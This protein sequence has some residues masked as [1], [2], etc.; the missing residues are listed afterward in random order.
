[1]DLDLAR[2]FNLDRPIA[3]RVLEKRI[4]EDFVK[5]ASHSGLDLTELSADDVTGLYDQYRHLASIK[6]ANMAKIAEAIRAGRAL[7][8]GI[9]KAAQTAP[10]PEFLHKIQVLRDFLATPGA[11]AWRQRIVQEPELLKQLI[12]HGALGAKGSAQMLVQSGMGGGT[13]DAAEAAIKALMGDEGL[14]AGAAAHAPLRAHL[15]AFSPSATA[16][17]P[18]PADVLD[19][20][21]SGKLFTPGTAA[22]DALQMKSWSPAG[23]GKAMQAKN[24]GAVAR[25]GGPLVAGGA[26]LLYLLGKRRESQDLARSGMMGMSGQM[27]MQ[28]MNP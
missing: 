4:K 14:K 26:G 16:R 8:H 6:M 1:M 23:I 15:T 5:S 10:S 9:M 11:A 21:V 27:G 18:L 2:R 13:P 22:Q 28:G 20:L 19:E 25:K 3:E 17:T 24:W 7:A 12:T